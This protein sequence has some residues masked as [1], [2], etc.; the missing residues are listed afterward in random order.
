M[1][2]ILHGCSP[3]WT[4]SWACDV[5]PV[6][7][8]LP[9]RLIAA[10]LTYEPADDG[11]CRCGQEQPPRAP[12]RAQCQVGQSCIDFTVSRQLD[13]LQGIDEA[14]EYEEACHPRRPL[15]HQA[16]DRSLHPA[17][18]TSNA[19]SWPDDIACKGDGQVAEHDEDGGD[20][21][22][23]LQSRLA[24]MTKIALGPGSAET[25]ISPGGVLERLLRSVFAGE[26]G[27][28]C[29]G[30]G[31]LGK[32]ANRGGHCHRNWDI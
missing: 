19:I 27:L 30:I 4:R 23:A 24:F 1:D 18:R 9:C 29:G 32:H 12:E 20:A 14:G 26:G 15:P 13:W 21:S 28:P 3:S 6:G 7:I 10:E 16:K 11:G 5:Q 8:R 25:Y 22:K 17:G 31:I 2:E